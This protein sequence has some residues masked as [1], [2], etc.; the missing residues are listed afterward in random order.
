MLADNCAQAGGTVIAKQL[1]LGLQSIGAQ[2]VIG[3]RM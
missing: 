1:Y 2:D 3:T